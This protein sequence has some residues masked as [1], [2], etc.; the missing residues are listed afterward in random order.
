MSSPGHRRPA[1]VVTSSGI[2]T[3]GDAIRRSATNVAATASASGGAEPGE[4]LPP[5]WGCWWVVAKVVSSR[6]SGHAEIECLVELVGV[7]EDAF[8]VAAAVAD[9]VFGLAGVVECGR[10]SSAEKVESF[11]FPG[12]VGATHAED[13]DGV[14]AE[15][16]EAGRAPGAADFQDPPLGPVGDVGLGVLEHPGWIAD[17]V[18][19]RERTSSAE[20]S[21]FLCC[22][23]AAGALARPDGLAGAGR[24][25]A[26]VEALEDAEATELL[27]GEVDEGGHQLIALRA[28]G[29]CGSCSSCSASASIAARA[30]AG[31]AAT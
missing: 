16:I 19:A 30:R 10:E 29:G 17:A 13:D 8:G 6:E 28:E 18:A 21:A 26:V 23:A 2:R 11:A 25:D 22:A 27:A 15:L 9:E 4:C 7:D 31:L 3:S 14:V 1:I 5:A 24:H 20:R 12:L